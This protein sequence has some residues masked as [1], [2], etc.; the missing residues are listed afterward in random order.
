MDQGFGKKVMH[1]AMVIIPPVENCTQIQK[2]RSK[3]D[4]QINRWMPHINMAFPFFDMPDFE[5]AAKTL[6]EALSTDT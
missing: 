2:I 3:H 1:T 6:Q 4:K 5:R